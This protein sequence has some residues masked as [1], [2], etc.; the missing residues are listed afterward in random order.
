MRGASSLQCPGPRPGPLRV[1]SEDTTFRTSVLTPA[2][3]SAP[4]WLSRSPCLFFYSKSPENKS[5]SPREY[6]ERVLRTDSSHLGT[7][8]GPDH[9][10]GRGGVWDWK[11]SAV[12][13]SFTHFSGITWLLHSLCCLLKPPGKQLSG[14][15][16]HN[17]GEP[18]SLSQGSPVSCRSPQEPPH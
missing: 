4:P 1:R 9:C 11:I 5:G 18:I 12:T 14:S 8:G 15:T 10:A 13:S 7:T 6:S 16:C 2:S 3:R 17:A